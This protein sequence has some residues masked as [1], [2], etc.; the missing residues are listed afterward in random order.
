MGS[1]LYRLTSAVD[2]EVNPG[3]DLCMVYIV[4]ELGLRGFDTRSSD[5]Q[6]ASNRP[7]PI[8]F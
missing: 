3:R 2:G 8:G 5:F 6:S 7:K 1:F 4:R